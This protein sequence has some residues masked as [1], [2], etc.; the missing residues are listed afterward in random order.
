MDMIEKMKKRTVVLLLLFGAVTHAA[1]SDISEQPVEIEAPL[2]PLPEE[3]HK[4][5]LDGE[6]LFRAARLYRDSDITT[7][8]AFMYESMARGCDKP[9]AELALWYFA[10]RVPLEAGENSNEKALEWL[11]LATARKQAR[12]YYYWGLIYS[13]SNIPVFDGLIVSEDVAPREMEKSVECFKKAIELGD[14]KAYR[15]LGK[16]YANGEA[17]LTKDITMAAEFYRM[18]AEKK[19]FTCTRL[20]ADL[21]YEGIGIKQNIPEAMKLYQWL[22]TEKAHNKDDYARAAYMLGKIFGQG[23]YV[24]KEKSKSKY[25]LKLAISLG[26][27]DAQ[28]ALNYY[29]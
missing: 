24:T 21:L 28:K 5:K 4:L 3:V 2:P 1:C 25:Y 15:Y 18:G 12:A 22:V 16:F 14:T 17:G 7:A 6:Q 11:N 26:S 19:D 8:K 9:M 27:K 20:Y 29:F 23:K 10:G 13:G